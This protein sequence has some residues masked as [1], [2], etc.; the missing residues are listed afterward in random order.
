V[1]DAIVW[2]HCIAAHRCLSRAAWLNSCRVAPHHCSVSSDHS[3][4]GFPLLFEPSII[5]NTRVF[6]F[7]PSSILQIWPKRSNFLCITFC[8]R[9]SANWIFLSVCLNVADLHRSA[10]MAELVSVRV[11]VRS[12]ERHLSWSVVISDDLWCLDWFLTTTTTAAAAAVNATTTTTSTIWPNQSLLFSSALVYT[13]LPHWCTAFSTSLNLLICILCVLLTPICCR[14]HLFAQPLPPAVLAL[15]PP[16][17]GT[18]YPL[19]SVVLPLQT[20]SVAF[21]KLSASSRPA[22]PPSG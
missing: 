1:S 8:S 15:Q 2:R 20:L 17:S 5:P 7:L 3:R 12:S 16:Q 6:I 4:W 14:F 18:H 21:L 19:A 10:E 9:V 13:N 22:A 11:R